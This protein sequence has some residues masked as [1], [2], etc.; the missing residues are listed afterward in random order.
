[1][2]AVCFFVT[3]DDSPPKTT[4]LSE[5]FPA[6]FFIVVRFTTSVWGADWTKSQ[7]DFLK[8]VNL[9]VSNTSYKHYKM[10]GTLVEKKGGEYQE[11]CQ[12]DSG[13]PLMYKPDGPKKR[14]VIIG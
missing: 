1:M 8:Q 3:L 10:F 12:G 7:S 9:K 14:W 6:P 5:F 13:G 11:P 2:K 4:L